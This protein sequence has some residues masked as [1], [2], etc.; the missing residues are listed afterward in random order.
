MTRRTA[1]DWAREVAHQYRRALRDVA[2][3]LCERLDRLAVAAGQGWI[4]PAALPAEAVGEALDQELPARDIEH[5]W[6]WLKASTIRKWAS[7]GLLEQRTA[8]DGSPR[9][10]VRDVMDVEARNRG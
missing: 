10:L 1:L 6:P 4:A 8:E 7:R 2:P 3:D 9:Y 5:F